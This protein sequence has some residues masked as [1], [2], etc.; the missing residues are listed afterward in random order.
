VF[1]PVIGES[2]TISSP[3]ARPPS[4][5]GRPTNVAIVNKRNLLPYLAVIA[6]LA[7]RSSE[8]RQYPCP[9]APPLVARLT[10]E[11]GWCD[12]DARIPSELF[13]GARDARFEVKNFGPGP[14][15]RDVCCLV[16]P[17]A[18]L[19]LASGVG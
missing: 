2:S 9:A 11:V 6:R 7:V 12:L 15:D 1:Q 4:F 19:G 5:R 3:T 18:Y 10:V 13:D 16:A 14:S 17:T 8:A